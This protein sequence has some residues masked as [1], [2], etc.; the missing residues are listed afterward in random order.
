M[1]SEQDSYAPN[2]THNAKSSVYTTNPS[3]ARRWAAYAEFRAMS[4]PADSKCAALLVIGGI[5]S[6]RVAAEALGIKNKNKVQ[7]AVN[8]IREGREPGTNG[9]P[10][11]LPRAE[12]ETKLLSWIA[13]CV[14]NRKYPEMGQ[15]VEEAERIRTG[16][17]KALGCNPELDPE[18]LTTSS[19]KT[20]LKDKLDGH[21]TRE[22]ETERLVT[23]QTIEE[24]FGVLEDLAA[25]RKW[26]P[27]LTFNWDET[28]GTVMSNGKAKVYTLRTPTKSKIK[29]YV[30]AARTHNEHTTIG[31]FITASGDT[32]KPQV[33]LPLIEV[34][35]FDDKRLYDQADI[36]GQKKGWISDEIMLDII[37]SVL[38]PEVEHRRIQ[39]KQPDAWAVLMWDG[40][41]SHC[42]EAITKLLTENNIDSVVFIPHASHIQQPLDLIIFRR[43]KAAMRRELKQQLRTHPDLRSCAISRRREL[44][45]T[46]GISAMHEATSFRSVIDS[47]ER[48]GLY[49]LNRNRPLGNPVVTE[50]Q[51]LAAE[52]VKR[53][54]GIKMNKGSGFYGGLE[55]VKKRREEDGTIP[56][57]RTKVDDNEEDHFVKED[58]GSSQCVEEVDEE[59]EDKEEEEEVSL[60]AASNAMVDVLIDGRMSAQEGDDVIAVKEA[61]R[62]EAKD[63]AIRLAKSEADLDERISA[64]GAEQSIS[65]ER[66]DVPMDG[67]CQ[68]H[69][70]MAAIS[71]F[72]QPLRAHFPTSAYQLRQLAVNWLEKNGNQVVS[73]GVGGNSRI[74]DFVD[75]EGPYA[76]PQ[77]LR[78]M[79]KPGTWGDEL[80]LTALA[81]ILHLKINIIC[82]ETVA[83]LTS[84][85]TTSPPTAN[86][87]IW[88]G[89]LNNFHYEA[90]L[91]SQ[92]FATYS[93]TE[94]LS[95]KRVSHPKMSQIFN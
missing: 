3:D 12:L 49:P 63:L 14:A 53:R 4:G 43:F 87:Q 88:I 44:Y 47:F 60:A 1:V 34:P 66:R 90:V 11:T 69:S 23:T 40:H 50:T 55:E 78:G 93:R 84:F 83:A 56:K 6:V 39:M 33:I 77:Y 36:H 21:S 58:G 64:I 76:W 85:I 95:K 74:C 26:D 30:E 51:E 16:D 62:K 48:A 59:T 70:V 2:R 5:C 71:Q 94:P 73:G 8:A 31:I 72:P 61:S 17:R 7:L 13:D 41:G 91:L 27:R 32:L 19:L 25:D 65:L 92:P 9:R 37:H 15:I 52:A 57:K 75:I 82:T 81:N 54:T 80:T 20:V 29:P 46:C 79:R 42:R 38:I 18:P 10:R 22:I 24:W 28:M 89:N 35:V 45:I 68:F 86:G 67:A